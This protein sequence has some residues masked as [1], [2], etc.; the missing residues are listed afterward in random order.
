M[1]SIV[2]SQ[3]KLKCLALILIFTGIAFD[4]DRSWHRT[5][6][7]PGHPAS[8]ASNDPAHRRSTHAVHPSAKLIMEVKKAETRLA[9]LAVGLRKAN[10][11]EVRSI[12]DEARSYL[13]SLPPE[14]AVAVIAEYLEDPSRNTPTHIDFSVGQLGVLSG[15]SSLRVA[16]LDWLGQL[17]SMK[18]E[19]VATKIL[20][21]PTESDEWAV[22]LR[23]FANVNSTF[24][25][26]EFLRSKTEE[27]IRNPAWRE[28]PSI[29]YLE[30]FDVLVQTHAVESTTLLAELVS[31][32]DPNGK[33]TAHAA[34]LA[35]DRLVIAEPVK[36]MKA[37]AVET[38]LTRAC[39]PMVA[40]M[41]ARADLRH[42]LQRELVRNYLLDP[43]RT[44]D[45][46]AAF[47]GVYPNANFTISKNLLTRTSTPTAQ[48][49]R[50]HDAAAL[51]IVDSWLVEP[52]FEPLTPYLATMHRRLVTFVNQASN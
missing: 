15:H 35:L 44:P 11:R 12:L 27:L 45:E 17:D 41:F 36:M 23:N 43:S 20:Q 7:D 30:A 33:A 3:T 21:K 1:N 2:H 46:L 4:I 40:N 50:A 52:A 13:F 31:N 14:T 49:L 26:R 19:I 22:S 37:L 39:G 47:S 25:G 10:A 8:M 18:A 29:G 9:L 6:Q 42:P 32:K 51:T 28:N 38:N 34:Y 24:E 48:E 16:L 5:S